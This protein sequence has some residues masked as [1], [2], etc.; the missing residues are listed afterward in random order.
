[1]QLRNVRDLLAGCLF[2]GFGLAFLYV[3]QDYQLGS[4]RR[5]GPAYFPVVL[6]LVLIGIGLATVARAFVVAGPPIRDVAGKA[7]ALVTAAVVLFGLMVQGAGLGIA[8]AALVLVSAP[9]SGNFRLMPTLVLAAAL[10]T[11]CVLVFVFGLGL[12]FP[13]LGPWLRG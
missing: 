12:P 13:A 8:A 5:M 7:L 3:A 1:M 6:S 10:A 4:A 2:L 9:A 11:F